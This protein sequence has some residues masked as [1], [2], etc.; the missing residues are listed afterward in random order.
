[1]Q[2]FTTGLEALASQS[3]LR[4]RRVV[5]GPQ[6]PLLQVEG[7]QELSFCSNDYLGLANHP[8]LIAAATDAL[9]RYGMGAGAS[10]LIS[11]HS[12]AHESL[13][14]E[15]AAFVGMPSALVFGSGYMANLG[16]TAALVGKGD[17]VIVDRLAHASLIDGARLSGASLKVFP[18]NDAVR[19]EQVL[20][21]CTTGRKLV[22][23]DA[24]FSMDGDLAP[25]A[26]LAAVCGRHD[27]WLLVDDAHG[28]GVLGPQ[29]RG[30]LA[31]A[32][33]RAA[34][35]LTMGT[36]GKAAGVAGAFVAGDAGVLAWILQR[37]RT[38]MFSTAHPPALAAA[39]S[40]SLALIAREDWR[41]ERLQ[42]LAAQLRAGVAGLPW[43]LLPSAT[44]IQ[45]LIVGENAA[46]RALSA[47]LRAQGIWVPAICPPTVP[48]GTARL[49][50]SLSAQHTSADVARLVAA[51]TALA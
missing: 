19:L 38:Y 45:P 8:A 18:H 36:L 30:S 31:L 2:D 32:G 42:A 15:L 23:T 29:G 39:T 12:R 25:L 4:T 35:V 13:E 9:Q 14:S 44:A 27:A 47:A 5:E 22:L 1:M 34:H 3:L 10:P 26:A 46:A 33:V 51:L 40:A 50:I 24:V 21:R 49:R 20:A 43:S 28:L 17:T 11:G 48:K 37:A 6:G 16:V 41:R 7:T